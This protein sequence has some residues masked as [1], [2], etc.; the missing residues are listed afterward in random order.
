MYSLSWSNGFRRGFKKASRKDIL[1]QK[2]I[3]SALEKLTRDPFDPSLKV[4]KLR[5]KLIG[6]WAC[7][8]E[9]DCRIVF[10][11]E[12]DPDTE[13]ELIVLVDI[14]TYDEVY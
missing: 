9:Y 2:K 11:F 4:H 10:T 3:F 14:G 6:L 13:N 1:L 5:G 12:K 7:Y 8:V